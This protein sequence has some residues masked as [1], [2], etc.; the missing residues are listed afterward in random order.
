M[1]EL[2]GVACVADVPRVQALRRGGAPRSCS[3]AE[4][5]T[6][7]EV[8]A[9]ASRIA[10][11]LIA[12]GV[13]TQERIAYLSKN[14]DHFLPCLL[15]A[16]KARVTLAPFNFR[17]AAPEIARLHR[18]QR[19]E[20]AV[21]RPGCRRPRGPGGRLARL[22]AADDRARLRPRRLR[23]AR[24]MDRSCGARATPGSKRTRRTT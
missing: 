21:R 6:F 3:R 14:T 23:A 12:S 13:R 11:A 8:D 16:C 4:T 2:E 22:E 18:G 20:D 7:A 15:G 5:T 9:M 10:N 17:L 1:I 24:R 19:R